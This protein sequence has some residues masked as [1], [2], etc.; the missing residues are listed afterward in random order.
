MFALAL[1]GWTVA[2]S[3]RCGVSQPLGDGGLA[4]AH[5]AGADPGV[6]R[7]GAGFHFSGEG[8]LDQAGACEHGL[9]PENA[10]G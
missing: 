4:P 3:I 2:R 7:K 9:D 8:G 5:A 10:I 6:L 1:S